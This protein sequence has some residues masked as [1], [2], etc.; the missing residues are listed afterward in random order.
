[1]GTVP[2]FSRSRKRLGERVIEAIIRFSG[3]ITL[4]IL[5]LITVMLF[6][7]GLPIFSYTDPFSFIFGT[8]WLP[9]SSSPQFGILPFIVGTL[10]VTLVALLISVPIGVGAAAFLSEIAPSSLREFLKP[11]IEILA[12]IPSIV[13]GFIGFILVAPLIQ[14]I[15]HLSTGLNGLT[16]GI[17]LSLICLP[18]IIS[19]SEDAL[20]AV[21]K[22]YKE[23]SYALGAT[24]WQTLRKVVIPAASPGIV[25]SVML[26]IGRAIGETMTVLMVSGG[27]L[28]IPTNIT[29]PMSVLTARIAIEINNASFRGLQFQALFAMGIILFLLT[30]VVNIISDLVLEK[31]KRRLGQL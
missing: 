31:Q 21:P 2:I 11:I 30:L 15:F 28:S 24:K 20:S 5:G 4:I 10:M 29:D 25:A 22:E 18:T 6:R 16:A 9:V 17:M 27:R 8:T 13:L 1:M 26:G 3:W 23:A 14:S 12:G 19:I 7:E